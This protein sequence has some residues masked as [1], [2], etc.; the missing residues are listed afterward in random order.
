[1]MRWA[2][3][4]ALIGACYLNVAGAAI[5]AGEKCQSVEAKCAIAAGGQCDSETG[6]WC[7]GVYQGRY[8]GGTSA[9][10]RACMTSHG[11]DSR[12]PTAAA[13]GA[14]KCVSDQGRCA[15]EVGG[16]CNRRTGSWCVGGLRNGIWCN[17]TMTAWLACLDR[18][19]AAR[20]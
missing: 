13:A 6:H 8:C 15:R 20:R 11:A 4:L 10:F 17:G 1:M 18:V 3:T 2:F 7:Y 12:V 16:I 9:A 19:R 5:A 14:D